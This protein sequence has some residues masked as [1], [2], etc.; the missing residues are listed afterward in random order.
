MELVA[1][2]DAQVYVADVGNH[3]LREV[4]LGMVSFV[5]TVAGTGAPGHL[6]GGLTS[7]RLDTPGGLTVSCAGTL[8]VAELGAMGNRLRAATLGDP[9][10]F[11]GSFGSI[12]TLAGDGTAATTQGTGRPPSSRSPTP[13]S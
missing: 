8:I 9:G 5:T 7:A 6:D 2:R 13:R 10:F 4:V 3:A 12:V 1:T 11:G